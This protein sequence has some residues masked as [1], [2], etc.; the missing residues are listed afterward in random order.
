MRVCLNADCTSYA[1]EFH[2]PQ[3]AIPRYGSYDPSAG[4][5]R[6][7]SFKLYDDD[8]HSPNVGQLGLAIGTARSDIVQ[9]EDKL[10]VGKRQCT[11]RKWF[12]VMDL[13][14]MVFV[15]A[16][17]A[18]LA[19]KQNREAEEIDLMEQTAQDYSVVVQD[20]NPDCLDPDE[21]KVGR[22]PPASLSFASP[23]ARVR[24]QYISFFC[25][26]LKEMNN[27]FLLANKFLVWRDAFRHASLFCVVACVARPF[28]RSG[29]GRCSW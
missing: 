9:N 8:G 20:P 29:L 19:V 1:G 2:F 5:W 15:S 16:V 7:A 12:G 24:I 26:F 18:A 3:D 22:H 21:W 10:T 6:D 28:S 14:M 17:L 27:I 11:V 23:G 25:S 4:T 13:T